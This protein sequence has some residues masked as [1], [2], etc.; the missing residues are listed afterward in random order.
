MKTDTQEMDVP[1]DGFVVIKMRLQHLYQYE[2]VRVCTL[3]IQRHNSL[4]HGSR[5]TCERCSSGASGSVLHV[6]AA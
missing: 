1:V 4:H 6:A 2:P 5:H 3:L